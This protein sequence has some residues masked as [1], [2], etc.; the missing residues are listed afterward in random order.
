MNISPVLNPQGLPVFTFG[1]NRA[2]KTHEYRG[3][4]VSLEWTGKGKKTQPCL[5]IWP[6]S[7][8]LTISTA[9]SLGAWMILR[10]AI[11]EFVGFTPDGKCT[12]SASEHCYRE[13]LAALPI[14][15]KD[16]N[17]KA[18]FLALVDAV[19]RFAP[20]LVH[21]PVAPRELRRDNGPALIDVSTINKT[22]G[23]VLHE[24]EL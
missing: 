20:D 12:G 14:L 17:D 18:A 19:I 11:T 21:M 7:N 9:E 4:V 23:R 15:G 5:C 10:R 16:P 22:S 24:A 8:I 2:W 6:A 1:G 13:C 3:Y